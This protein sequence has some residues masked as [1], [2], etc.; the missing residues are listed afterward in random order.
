[1]ILLLLCQFLDDHRN[2]PSSSFIIILLLPVRLSACPVRAVRSTVTPPPSNCRFLPFRRPSR[3]LILT[4]LQYHFQTS[5][6]SAHLQVLLCQQ[7][8]LLSACGD[9]NFTIWVM[10]VGHD[11]LNLRHN[12]SHYLAW[13]SSTCTTINKQQHSR[14]GV[15]H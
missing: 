11:K 12:H 3:H 6:G 15:P 10:T 2:S 4:F 1:M 8:P 7:T 14:R 5:K 9:L 13:L